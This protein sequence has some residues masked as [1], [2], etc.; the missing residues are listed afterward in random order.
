MANPAVSCPIAPTL[1]EYIL[2]FAGYSQTL[3]NELSRLRARRKEA[4][5]AA[6]AVEFD[7]KKNP[8]W[9]DLEVFD[10]EGVQVIDRYAFEI[11]LM[12]KYPQILY[13]LAMP[14]FAPMP[15]EADRFFA[16]EPLVA[17]N[18]TLDN[19]PLGTGPFRLDAMSPDEQIVLARN[20]NYRGEAYPTEGAEGDREAGYLEDAGQTMPFIDRAIYKREK[21][22]ISSWNKFIQGYYDLSGIG[23]DVFDQAVQMGDEG[24]SLSEDLIAKG[25]RLNTS[26]RPTSVYMAFNMLDEM[27]GGYDEKG[28]KL[29]QALSI[30]LDIEEYAQIFLNGRALVA[31]GAIPPGIFGHLEGEAGVNPVTHVWDAAAGA[32]ARR[33]LEDARRLLAEAGYPNGVSRDGTPLVIGFD[34]YWSGP[35]AKARFDWMRKQFEQLEID[36][37]IRQTDYNRFRDKTRQGNWQFMFWGWNAD[38]PDPENFY[39]LLYG[40]NGQVKYGGANHNNYANPE[41]DRFFELM[42]SMTNGPER[43]ALIHRMMR[44]AQED[45]PWI[46][47]YHPVSYGLYHEWYSN[48]KA[49]PITKNRLK[50]KRVDGAQRERRRA[51]WNEP[52]W[53]PLVLAGGLLLAGSVPAVLTVRRRE[54]EAELE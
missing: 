53:W 46:W 12:K 50:Y 22:S 45:A 30:A 15:R 49:I 40:Q 54:R 23:T 16:Q 39:F 41:F 51:A 13:W 27:V 32:P 36:L 3:D 26:V 10:L 20:E 44:I 6:S 9:I 52:I 1:G 2:G 19:R 25:I 18:L 37:Q 14:F 34:T 29:R 4:L 48:S 5:G 11:T 43:L 21:E 33:P 24:T 35:A 17:R 38:Y 28:R 42:E 47:G 31:Q 7:E 8:I